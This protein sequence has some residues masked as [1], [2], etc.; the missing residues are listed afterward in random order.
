MTALI[1]GWLFAEV[2]PG[3]LLEEPTTMIVDFLLVIGI[4]ANIYLF[5]YYSFSIKEVKSNFYV[6]PVQIL[7][8]QIPFSIKTVIISRFLTICMLSFTSSLIF[9]VSFYFFLSGGEIAT[10]FPNYLSFSAVWILMVLGNAGFIVAAEPG[11][12]MT[13]LYIFIF[14]AIVLICLLGALLLIRF[15]TDQF[16]LEWILIGVSEAPILLPLMILP[17][18]MLM[19]FLWSLYMKKYMLKTDYH[20]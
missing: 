20:V 13:K 7:L 2:L 10:L 19:L 3:F 5:R 8:R 6:A 12:T 18:S 1:F 14:N 15:S 11:A 16:L 9:L 4:G 17:V